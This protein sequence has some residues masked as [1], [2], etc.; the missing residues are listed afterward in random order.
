MFVYFQS[1]DATIFLMPKNPLQQQLE[2][3]R[4]QH[5]VDYVRFESHGKKKLGTSELARLNEH[6][7]GHDS[8]WRF[9]PMRI[10]IPGGHQVEFNVIGNPV[11]TARTI[12]GNAFEKA[13]NG[14]VIEAACE[15]YMNLMLEHLFID[16]NRRTAV[17]ATIWLLESYDIN[18][19]PRDL[20][21]VPVGNLRDSSERTDFMDRCRNLCEK[22]L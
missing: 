11:S 3:A 18:V 8:P 14:Q 4:F 22:S 7:S 10:S 1:K 12:L 6:L 17:L 5:G 19:D 16:A 2:E 20:Y 21:Q 15:L 13:G 9:D